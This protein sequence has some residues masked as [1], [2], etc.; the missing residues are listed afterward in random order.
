MYVNYYQISIIGISSL[1][2]KTTFEAN[3]LALINDF[4]VCFVFPWRGN[5]N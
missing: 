2:K 5:E 3:S 4:Q 1:D